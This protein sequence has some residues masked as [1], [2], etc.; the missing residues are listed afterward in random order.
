MKRT[1]ILGISAFYHDSAACLVT[2]GEIVAAAQEE[3]FTRRKGDESFPAQAID[4]CLRAGKLGVKDLAYVGFYEKPLLKFERLLET[5]VEVAPRGLSSFLK[6]TPLW[7]KERLHTEERIRDALAYK[8]EMLY[9][10]H[11]E[12]H[13]ASAFYPSPFQQAAVLTV[14]GVGEWATCT[15]G[16]GDGN[17]LEIAREMRWPDSVGLLY[18]AFTYFIGFKV[19]SGEYK[20]MGLAPYGQPRYVGV[21]YDRLIDLRADGSFTMN[22]E[23]FN[24]VSGLTMTN[25]RFASLFGGPPR[26]PE[27]PLT[28]REMDLARSVQV[29]CEEIIL[30]MAR[31]AHRD[32]GS[33]NLCMAGG[34]ALNAVA[35]GR[36]LREGP[37][38][39]VWIQPAAGDAGG[40]VGVAQLIW[41]R[42]LAKPRVTK[43]HADSMK[44]AYLG[45]QW[46]PEECESELQSVGARYERVAPTLLHQRVASAL[47]EG[48]VIGWFSGRMEFGPRALGNRSILGDPRSSRMQRQINQKVKFRE[49]FRPFAPSVLRERVRDFFELEVDSPYMLLVAP[50]RTDCRT[51]VAI[52]DDL[53]P[54]ERLNQPRSTIPAV[55]HIDYSARIQTVDAETNPEYHALLKAFE[56]ITGC[57]VL[58]NTSFNIRGEPIVCSPTDAFRCFMRTDIDALVIGQFLLDKANQDEGGRGESISGGGQRKRAEPIDSVAEDRR[59]VGTLV[60]ACVTMAAALFWGKRTTAAAASSALA[61][62]LSLINSVAPS[63]IGRVRRIWQMGANLM[64]MVMTPIILALVFCLVVTPTALIRRML[65]RSS[66]RHSGQCVTVWVDRV[67][68]ERPASDMRRQF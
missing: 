12:S 47:A 35:N 2:D 41:H 39:S 19:N 61:I 37:F 60:V 53:E 49:G 24:Y 56:G 7:V 23:Y 26:K 64:S 15:T 65:R 33:V 50:V 17:R 27:A 21:I 52:E 40:A 32:T 16:V 45:P 10:E 44:G 54:V 5:Y 48:K 57:P 22:Q 30:R 4:Y 13:A 38:E 59:F 43:P 34:V 31:T 51:A 18:S 66:L 14:D 11:H 58:V 67:P 1:H 20:V 3:R 55:T 25:H 42:Y 9:A 36:I 8:G 28:R 46:T 29:V 6:A 62:M 68:A 63:V